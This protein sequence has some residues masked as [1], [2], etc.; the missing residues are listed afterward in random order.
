MAQ[1]FYRWA[2]PFRGF[3]LSFLRYLSF[4]GV[5]YKLYHPSPSPESRL[6]PAISTAG[7][8]STNTLNDSFNLS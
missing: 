4:E 1:P 6:K 8:V 2:P 7:Y 3:P 5:C